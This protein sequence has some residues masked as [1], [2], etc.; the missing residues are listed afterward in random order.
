MR[1]PPSTLPCLPAETNQNK[2]QKYPTASFPTFIEALLEFE[3]DCKL[4]V[5]G[6]GREYLKPSAAAFAAAGV[7]V[8]NKFCKMTNL[9]WIINSEEVQQRLGWKRASVLNDFEAVGYGVLA[10]EEADQHVIHPAKGENFVDAW[11][12]SPSNCPFAQGRPSSRDQTDKGKSNR[13]KL[14]CVRDCF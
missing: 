3:N 5:R 6:G 4:E 11:N 7:V 1:A 12:R 10:V 2:H 8:E 9:D 13:A 14:S